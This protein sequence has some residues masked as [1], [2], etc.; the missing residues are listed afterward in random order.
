MNEIKSRVAG[1]WSRRVDQFSE[2]RLREL[3][4]DKAALWMRE[5]ETYLPQKSGLKILDV[6]TGTGLF[7]FMLAARGHKVTGIDLT[8]SMIDEA[9]RVAKSLG[10]DAQ[11]LVMD[12]ENPQFPARSFDAVVTRNLTWT[13]PHLD[14]AYKK[15][16]ELL[17]PGGVLIN[18]DADYCREKPAPLPENH[19][20][21]LIDGSL[22]REYEAIKDTLRPMQC[23]RP[24]WDVELLRSAGF[25][26]I[27]VDTSVWKRI[28]GEV[29]EFYNPTPIFTISAVA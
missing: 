7:A 6:G 8:A 13:L 2:Q 28:Y 25:G 18:F 22:M 24:Q 20:H 23:A 5:F 11:F 26:G 19:A 9:R 12:A 16:H 1:Y 21:K 14:S 3:H 15:W 27:S 10:S 29:D 4:S 17:K